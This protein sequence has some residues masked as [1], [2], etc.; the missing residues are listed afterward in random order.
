MTVV[1]AVNG[2]D[3]RESDGNLIGVGQRQMK[4]RKVKLIIH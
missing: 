3:G 1:R 4:V 2:V